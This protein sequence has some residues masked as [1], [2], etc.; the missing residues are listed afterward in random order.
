MKKTVYLLLC[1][2]LLLTGCGPSKVVPDKKMVLSQENTMD[3]QV[4]TSKVVIKY[5]SDTK[6]VASGKFSVKYE[7]MA[8]TE[9][10]GNILTDL[11]NRYTII[12]QLEGVEATGNATETG[13]GF[14]EEW[15]YNTIDIEEALKADEQQKNFVENGEYSLDKIKEHPWFSKVEYLAFEEYRKCHNKFDQSIADKMFELGI[16]TKSLRKDLFLGVHTDAT[17]VYKML[18]RS[19]VTE[20]MKTSL[21]P[22]SY[23]FSFIES[24]LEISGK[25]KTE[26][27][28]RHRRHHT[29]S[30]GS[31]DDNDRTTQTRPIV[32]IRTPHHHHQKRLVIV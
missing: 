21:M 20:E 18:K 7:N 6:K 3:G 10:N 29:K 17:C 15:D 31:S 26:K 4:F 9:T 22:S 27:H 2:M 5:D 24:Q 28:H 1:L 23:S 16:D 30:D 19:K 12:E 8:K 11:N 25:K 13:F 14:E 32:K